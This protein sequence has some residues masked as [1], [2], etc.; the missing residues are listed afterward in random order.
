MQF[1]TRQIWDYRDLYSEMAGTALQ[2]WLDCGL[3]KQVEVALGERAHGDMVR[4]VSAIQALPT[5][6]GSV[7][8]LASDTVSVSS[9]PLPDSHTRQEIEKSLRQLH[10]WRKGP[11][12][13]MGVSID[14]EWRSDW[15][16]E[17]LA[18][19]VELLNG[20]TVLDVGCGN[21]YHCW[22]M[23]GAGAKL[24][25]GIDPTQLY[26]MQFWA[27]RHF[28]GPQPVWVLPLG[29]EALPTELAA[30]DTV[31]SMGVLYHR[32]SPLDHLLELRG[33]L[34]SRGQ[35]VL[36]TLVVEGDETTALVPHGRYAS[37]RNVWFLPSVAML[38]IWLER[39]G[40]DTIQVI[41]VTATS[42]EEQRSTDWMTF[43]SLPDFLHPKD[44]SRTV[45][46]YP[47]PKR[48]I[49]TALRKV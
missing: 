33:S 30:F 14:T 39:V 1:N 47:A 44:R 34:R 11:F 15:K 46:G 29:I 5:I 48:A 8:D 12:G 28:T 9:N 20:R 4:W 37:M 41:D 31:F 16:W 23:A 38:K 25:I 43:K 27:I 6:S 42:T 19:A 22:R 35:L 49:L 3:Q 45:E 36:E 18:D 17:R 13:I 21:G 26:T 32:R 10:P 24:V 40:F 2:K 7:V